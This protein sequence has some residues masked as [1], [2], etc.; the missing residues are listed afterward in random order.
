MPANRRPVDRQAKRDEIVRVA[1]GLFTDV[2]FDATPM[3]QLAA[4]AGVTTNTVYWYVEDKDALLVAVLDLLLAEALQ[5]YEQQD[6][7]PLHEQLL[8]A[9]DR[10]QRFHR[11]VSV[12]HV[13]A[14][15]AA[16]VAAW[17]DQFHALADALLADGFRRAGVAEADLPA[18]GRTGTYVLEG[19]LTHPQDETDRRAV[20]RMLTTIAAPG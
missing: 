5:E 14:A 8:W 13:R 6:G 11:L 1:A 20:L 17:H 15:V 16:V 7:A 10:L 12:V 9:V 18:A 2:G 4:A 3:A 19:L